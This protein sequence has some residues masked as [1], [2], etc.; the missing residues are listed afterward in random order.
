MNN[1]FLGI[2]TN[3]G[4]REGNLRE[5]LVKIGESI[6]RVVDSSSVYETAAWGFES[7]NDFLNMVV[8]VETELAPQV[9]LKKALL[10]ESMLGRVRTGE[11]Y[12]SRVIDIDILLYDDRVIEEKGLKIPHPLMQERRFVLVPLCEI[13]PDLVHPV[14][15]KSISLLL[16]ECR[17]KGKIIKL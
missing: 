14:L 15:G 6:G 7:E 3:L 1:V 8:R 11:G 17:D 5:A 2:G 9:L 13:A 16:G 4:E 10:I 12:G